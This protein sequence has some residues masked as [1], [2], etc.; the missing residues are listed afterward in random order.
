MKKI[1]KFDECKRSS[2]Y[3]IMIV[4][5]AVMVA[6]FASVA[7]AE[8]LNYNFIRPGDSV[9]LRLNTNHEDGTPRFMLIRFHGQGQGAAVS[10][11]C[12]Q[13]RFQIIRYEDYNSLHGLR[14]DQVMTIK[15]IVEME[16]MG[17]LIAEIDSGIITTK[18][19]MILRAKKGATF[20]W[21]KA[22]SFT[23]NF[24][25]WMDN[26]AEGAVNYAVDKG[27]DVDIK[28]KWEDTK[29]FVEETG[30]GDAARD[31]I[32]NTTETFSDIKREGFGSWL[33]KKL[34]KFQENLGLP[35]K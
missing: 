23:Q 27:W 33:E 21:D 20:V 29:N 14:F 2:L 9:L 12:D 10:H 11:N 8:E 17:R 35:G 1:W 26:V 3:L 22:K 30:L 7:E 15:N 5:I 4:V 13:S 25:H 34:D 28:N 31:A 16:E 6:I 24:T 19:R 18:D 32:E